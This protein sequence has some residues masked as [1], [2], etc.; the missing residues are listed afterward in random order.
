MTKEIQYAGYSTKPSDYDCPDGQLA[1]SLNL[2]N[3]DNQ[4]RPVFQPATKVTMPSN[5]IV[6]FVH[7]TNAYTHY[8]VRQTSTDALYWFDGSTSAITYTDVLN[9]NANTHRLGIYS[10]V[11]HIN[12][13]GNTLMVFTPSDIWYFLWN[14]GAYSLLGNHL[15]EIAISFGL[16]GY[17]LLYSSVRE[18][19]ADAA[20]GTFTISFDGD[21]IQRE[22]I[23]REFSDANK[24]TITEQ[25]M[26]KVNKF[27]AEQTVE[28]GRFC[29]P[30]F[31]RWAYRLYDGSHTMH[32]APVLMNPSTT[33]AP[34][35]LWRRTTGNGHYEEAEL[36]IMM[37]P[38]S[39]DYRLTAYG[40]AVDL[41]KWKDIISGIDI[42]ISKPIYTYDQD[43][44]VK[45]FSDD[46]NF[47]C[48]FIGRI[49]L[50]DDSDRN[51][52]DSAGIAKYMEYSYGDIYSRFLTAGRDNDRGYPNTT[53]NLPEF[54]EE[55]QKEN[56]ESVANFY[57]LH[58]LQ[59]SELHVSSNRTILPVKDDY[60]QSLVNR[61]VMTD[62]YLSHDRLAAASA[63]GF[64]ARLNLAGVKRE[65]FSGFCAHALFAYCECEYTVSVSGDTVSITPQ[66][67]AVTFTTDITMRVYIRE[68]GE[69]YYVENTS[70]NSMRVF[71]P[72]AD[73]WTRTVTM[74]DGSQRVTAYNFS[75]GTMT[76]T[77]YNTS[78]T[79]ANRYRPTAFGSWIFYPNANAHKIVVYHGATKVFA[80]D[81][82]KHDFLNGAYAFLGNTSERP[83]PSL[84]TYTLPANA[85]PASGILIDVAN[86]IY[87]SEVNNPF[88]FPLIGINTVGDGRILGI[89]SANKALSQGQFGSFPLYA[90]TD[91]GVWALEVSSSGTYTARQPITRDVCIN[92]DSITQ[93]DNSVLFAT[94][95]G[96]MLIS[97]S[98]TTCITDTISDELPFDVTALPGMTQLHSM[99]DH[100]ADACIPTQPFTAFLSGCQMVYDYVHQR[101]FVFNPSSAYSYAYVFSL[102][103]KMWGMIH[104]SL[105]ARVNSYPDGLAMAS[106]SN[107]NRLVSFSNVGEAE[108]SCLFCTRSLKL[109]FPGIYKAVSEVV[110]RGYFQRGDVGTVLY[111]S[112]DNRN[113]FVIWS[114]RDHNL[115]G[116]RGSPY[117]YL[118][119]AGVA[120]LTEDKSLFGAT[121]N[122]EVRFT[123]RLR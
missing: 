56:I 120:T 108:C 6:L 92:P 66:T 94:D 121:F 1:V 12:A 79:Y 81:L 24:A 118:R 68:N 18:D 123:N 116:F 112:R 19:G 99:L 30:F 32:S 35:V 72:F 101:I 115:R 64:N 77:R 102:K 109:D 37:V 33:P 57:L 95:R 7:K 13:V 25:V 5:C 40:D 122:F 55:K 90:F 29:F 46:N 4:L 34:I 42:F 16:V 17:P 58:T 74:S 61:E 85:S 70:P 14:D 3:E 100:G 62:D 41:D 110:Q 39:I 119:I 78:Q 15:P 63:Y 26:A 52:S 8:I 2:I 27:I 23:Y 54:T 45:S 117:K 98:D 105:I 114:S 96:I 31:V 71:V 59:M 113:W 84:T 50:Y 104:S 91:E 97:G 11:S 89:S 111:G 86:K 60:L 47:D 82:K 69:E 73:T 76:V 21:G 36:D 93:L 49:G 9:E 75:E 83:N 88:F 67:T 38:A 107:G 65:L 44:D 80:C 20:R 103:S 48:K 28:K 22:D 87:T 43:G 51:P 10:N 106:G 53:L